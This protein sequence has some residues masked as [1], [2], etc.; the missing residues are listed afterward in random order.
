MKRLWLILL[1][2]LNPWIYAHAV[3]VLYYDSQGFETLGTTFVQGLYPDVSSQALSTLHLS[4]PQLSDSL[5]DGATAETQWFNHTQYTSNSTANGK[6]AVSMMGS[7]VGTSVYRTNNTL[8]THNYDTL[9][10]PVYVSTCT[11][12]ESVTVE[13]DLSLSALA[14]PANTTFALRPYYYGA[15]PPVAIVKVFHQ[16]DI[17]INFNTELASETVTGTRDTAASAFTLEWSHHS[18]TLP[19]TSAMLNGG[20]RALIT[21]SGAGSATAQQNTYISVDNL[22]VY[23]NTPSGGPGC[24]ATIPTSVPTTNSY[25]LWAMTFLLLAMG[26]GFFLNE[27]R[28]TSFKTKR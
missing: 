4:Y 23:R 28:S 5:F 14:S 22:V 20:T 12:M 26:G 27:K 25:A 9:S 2:A 1:L 19:L 21:I 6:Y 3:Q 11:N 16:P 18:V 13:F 24:I 7:P 10:L 8:L 17:D 15:V